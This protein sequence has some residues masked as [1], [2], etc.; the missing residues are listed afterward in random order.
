MEETTVQ[1]IEQLKTQFAQMQAAVNRF[2]DAESSLKL[3][4]RQRND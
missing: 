3:M 4:T 1:K 2:K